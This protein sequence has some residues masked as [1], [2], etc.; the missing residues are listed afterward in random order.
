ML[1]CVKSIEIIEKKPCE[2]SQLKTLIADK[3]SRG[4]LCLQ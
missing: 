4:K 3:Y 1:R 2:K